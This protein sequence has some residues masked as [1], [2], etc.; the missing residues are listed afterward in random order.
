[1]HEVAPA[2]KNALFNYCPF[3]SPNTVPLTKDELERL[4]KHN[5]PIFSFDTSAKCNNVR[6]AVFR[7]KRITKKDAVSLDE[8]HSLINPN[9]L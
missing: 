5:I 8:L 9:N 7:H 2:Y 4:Q 3:I 1:M 6:N